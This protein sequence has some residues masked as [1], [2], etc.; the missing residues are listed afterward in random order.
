MRA[1]TD[2]ACIALCSF[3]IRILHY[4]PSCAAGDENKCLKK[5]QPAIR[6]CGGN[7]YHPAST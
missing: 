2:E 6:Q 4:V 5:Y 7:N 3:T 1:V